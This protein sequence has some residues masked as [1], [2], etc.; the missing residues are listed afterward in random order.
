MRE[1]IR[2]SSDSSVTVRFKL[3]YG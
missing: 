1:L 2:D 3:R